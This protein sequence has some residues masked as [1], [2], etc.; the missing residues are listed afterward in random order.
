MPSIAGNPRLEST[1]GQVNEKLR[2]AVDNLK[3]VRMASS[4][5]AKKTTKPGRSLLKKEMPPHDCSRHD[6][7]AKHHRS[8]ET[9]MGLKLPGQ[10]PRF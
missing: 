7:F 8:E 2:R 9:A 5:R 10:E 3:P 6:V 1:A 4:R